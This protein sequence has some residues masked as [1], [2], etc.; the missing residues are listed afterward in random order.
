[1]PFLYWF[2]CLGR[3]TATQYCETSDKIYWYVVSLC[4]C[5]DLTCVIAFPGKAGTETT[6]KAFSVC[7]LEDNYDTIDVA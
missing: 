5:C 4:F 3:V 7:F 2:C 6:R 1:M